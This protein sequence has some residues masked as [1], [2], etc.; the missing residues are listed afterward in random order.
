LTVASGLGLAGGLS[1]SNRA[2]LRYHAWVGA[3]AAIAP[4]GS[5]LF[6]VRDSREACVRIKSEA[7]ESDGRNEHTARADRDLGRLTALA[8]P[9]AILL[10]AAVITGLLPAPSV[11]VHRWT[12]SFAFG[13]AVVGLPLIAL[14]RRSQARR[15]ADAELEHANPNAAPTEAGSAG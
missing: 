3:I 2:V 12:A 14:L 5:L 4:V 8:W 10:L 1:G 15:N 11:P 6:A 9:L 7:P 13:F